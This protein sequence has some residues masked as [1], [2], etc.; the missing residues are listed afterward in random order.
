[1]EDPVTDLAYPP[2]QV[3]PKL[4]TGLERRR[5]NNDAS[6]WGTATIP[7][8]QQYVGRK[9]KKLWN[10]IVEALVGKNGEISQSQSAIL[11]TIIRSEIHC[12]LMERKRRDNWG[13]MTIEQAVAVSK[14]IY[15]A[16]AARDKMI[17]SL[18]ID[19]NELDLFSA[20]LKNPEIQEDEFIETTGEV[21]ESAEDLD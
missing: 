8:G 15:K 16:S 5:R 10:Q 6:A 14:E 3:D 19:R 12:Q 1:M 20:A 21:V 11:H 9:A 7:K 2:A 4:K 13:T 17:L 18:G